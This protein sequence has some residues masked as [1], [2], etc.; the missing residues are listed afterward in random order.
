MA[1]FAGAAG[2]QQGVPVG[3]PLPPSAHLAFASLSGGGATLASAHAPF[4][5]SGV[6]PRCAGCGRVGAR[7]LAVRGE[8][9]CC[10]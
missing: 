5:A 8:A 3:V 2:E 4:H 9:R 6:D 7:R 1:A 10:H